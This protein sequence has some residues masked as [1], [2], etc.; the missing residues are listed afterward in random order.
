MNHRNLIT[1]DLAPW[2][3]HGGLGMGVGDSM[4]PGGLRDGDGDGG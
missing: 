3:S 1:N 4:G 2:L